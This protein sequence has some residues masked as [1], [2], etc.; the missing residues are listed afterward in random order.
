MPQSPFAEIVVQRIFRAHGDER[1]SH[2]ARILRIDED[3]VV[4]SMR[5]KKKLVGTDA[6][7]VYRLIASIYYDLFEWERW[8]EKMEE[9][10]V[11]YE[12]G[13]DEKA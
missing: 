5:F 10:Y 1:S 6:T 2:G 13:N 11:T 12:N 3:P 9:V 4:K 7:R 8:Q